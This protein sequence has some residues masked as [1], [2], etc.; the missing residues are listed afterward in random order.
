[1]AKRSQI[2]TIA[3][4]VVL[5]STQFIYAV[6]PPTNVVFFLQIL[7]PIIFASLYGIM[8]LYMGKGLRSSKH[9]SYR[10]NISAVLAT[11][12][13]VLAILGVSL[14]FG[15]GRNIMTPNLRVV[16]QNAW[17]LA[18]PLFFMEAVR[19]R[20]IKASSEKN[21]I[22]IVIA[23]SI[24]Y[25]LSNFDE[26]RTLVARPETL[27]PDLFFTSILP[28]TTAG[29]VVSFIAI[30]GNLKSVFTVSF[31]YNIGGSFSP[32]LPSLERIVWS[33]LLCGLMFITAIVHYYL[34]DE[35]NHAQRTRI[36]RAAKHSPRNPVGTIM[37]VAVA[38]LI[39]A[40]F[41]KAFTFYPVV[42]LTGSMTGTI[43]KGS[44]VVMRRIPA[45]EASSIVAVSDILHYNYRSVEFVHRVIDFAEDL[46]GNRQL[47]TK[48]DANEYPDP[49]PVPLRDVL[50]TPVLT[51]PYIGYPNIIFRAIFGGI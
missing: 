7:R 43:D 49:T 28:A 42:I 32:I 21:R 15:G 37:T 31:L 34:T 22:Y 10:A 8:R 12:I 23:L 19:Y 18:V 26:L 30:N 27:S 44:L 9:K 6:M 25:A 20:L 40:F 5:A 29:V 38:G 14:V 35:K 46:E 51:I 13:Y 41:F 33:L 3:T 17:S 11:L 16:A 50:G 36:A 24:V 45:E 2:F 39:V 47:V 4:C 1:M 48:G